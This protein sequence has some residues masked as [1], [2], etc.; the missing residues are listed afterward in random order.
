MSDLLTLGFPGSEYAFDCDAIEHRFAFGTP[1]LKAT[2]KDGFEDDPSRRNWPFVVMHENCVRQITRLII[3]DSEAAARAELA[4][5]SAAA[6]PGA[7]LTWQPDGQVSAVTTQVLNAVVMP[8]ELA[9]DSRASAAVG[10]IRVTVTLETTPYWLGPETQITPAVAEDWTDD[11]SGAALDPALWLTTTPWET[12]YTTG[13]LAYYADAQ[14]TQGSGKTRITLADVTA[15]GYDYQS[16]F[17][18]SASMFSYGYFEVSC[19]FPAGQ[20]VWPAIWLT[21]DSTLEID[22]ME[23][24]GA[25]PTTLYHTLHQGPDATQIAQVITA[26]ATDY[27]AAAHVYA[28]DWQPGYVK[29]YIDDVLVGTYTGTIPGDKM[30]LCINLAVGGED[31]WGGTL[32]AAAIASMPL[33]MDIQYAY[34][35]G[36]LVDTEATITTGTPFTARIPNIPGDVPALTRIR[37]YHD[38]ATSKLAL[39]LRSNPDGEFSPIDDYSGT[40]D[41]DA[42]GGEAASLTMTS[43]PTLIGTADTWDVAANTG[44]KRIFARVKSEAVAA[45]NA[46]M[47]FANTVAPTVG[48]G[49]SLYGTSIPTVTAASGGFDVLDLGTTEF[50]GGRVPSGTS[51]SFWSPEVATN[52]STDGTTLTT[53]SSTPT[54]YGDITTTG[55]GF[56][57]AIE[58]PPYSFTAAR[59]GVGVYA[60]S[61]ALLDSDE[62]WWSSSARGYFST[63]RFAIAAG[64]YT[65]K[66]HRASGGSFSVG[67]TKVYTNG[68][69]VANRRVYEQSL[70]G[71]GATLG[72]QAACSESS[73]AVLLDSVAALPTD[74]ACYVYTGARAAGEGIVIDL[75]SENDADHDTYVCDATDTGISVFSAVQPIG[76]FLLRP[77]TNV[78]VGMAATPGTDPPG[79]GN[80]VFTYR[81]RWLLPYT[82]E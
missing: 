1:A 16:G 13:Q 63:K 68:S 33:Y 46:T 67:V 37:Y 51:D 54:P 9:F 74:E 81:G 42:L 35:L 76:P 80:L 72:V 48:D 44:P 41:T 31:S 75:L 45:A 15:N 79:D 29:W 26:G 19:Q 18:R 59:Y 82:G 23:C 32:D 77:G 8:E 30:W 34:A 65:V 27:S 36:T 49:Y 66:L 56:R 17:M 5:I 62:I 22:I 64:T 24:L 69:S 52:E 7:T 2:S 3:A 58:A 21:N 14:I 43:T 73:K 57:I 10:R 20:G 78:L 6:H 55:D 40:E 38:Q 11:M 60:E 28:V 61:G 25:D 12:R 71:I 53:L 70:V 39:A 47:R 4:A 50:P